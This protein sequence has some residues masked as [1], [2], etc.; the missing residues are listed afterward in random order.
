MLLLLCK[1]TGFCTQG[2]FCTWSFQGIKLQGSGVQWH[3][4][5]TKPSPLQIHLQKWHKHQNNIN[6]LK[7]KL[8]NKSSSV[9]MPTTYK[10]NLWNTRQANVYCKHK[11]KNENAQA[12]FMWSL[13]QRY[14]VNTTQHN[15][16]TNQRGILAALLTHI[17]ISV[18]DQQVQCWKN[19][20]NRPHGWWWVLV[21][22]QIHD[23]PCHISQEADRDIRFDKREQRMHYTQSNYIV[24]KMGAISNYITCNSISSSPVAYKMCICD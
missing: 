12:R 3:T 11:T 19:L 24:S 1:L 14:C 7:W 23:H 13:S 9:R 17:D 2:P 6:I 10:E 5:M 20:L 16:C 4:L 18:M 8:K 15:T 21:S 22:T